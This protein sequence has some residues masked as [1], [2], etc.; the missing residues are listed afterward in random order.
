MESSA[1]QSGRTQKMLDEVISNILKGDS[2]IIIVCGTEISKRHIQ[3]RVL[4]MLQEFGESLTII[5]CKEGLIHLRK[6]RIEFIVPSLVALRS[7]G[8]NFSK[9]HWDHYAQEMRPILYEEFKL[10]TEDRS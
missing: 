1:R 9:W 8:D 5:S 6:V 7:R 4:K 3:K 2:S 10:W